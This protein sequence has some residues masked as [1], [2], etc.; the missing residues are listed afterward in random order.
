MHSDRSFVRAGAV[1]VVIAGVAAVLAALAVAFLAKMRSDGE[2][3]G[4]LVGEAQARI[5]LSAGLMYVAET[6]R[7]GW[8]P[9]TTSAPVEAFG[10]VDVRTGLP[11]P[12]DQL[13]RRLFTGDDLTG[14]GTVY[15][16]VGTSV[17]CPLHVLTRPPCA[18]SPQLV[19]NP[20]PGDPTLAWSE[21]VSFTQPN[22]QPIG[23]DFA[24]FLA[25][26]ARIR[27]NSQ[28]MSWFR[29]HR[30]TPAEFV[31][32][33][34]A[35]ASLGYR[36]W[37]EAQGDGAFADRQTFDEIRRSETILWYAA[38]WNPAVY[39]S[40]GYL[41]HFESES[42]RPAESNQPFIRGTSFMN[43]RNFVGSFL[44]IERL[45]EMPPAW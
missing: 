23:A 11:G 33:C 31:I 25:G 14:V 17:R 27:T 40:V 19:A 22:P 5:M 29:V 13:G 30:R 39:S 1:L 35:G 36:D 38:E 43:P 4:A 26:D 24:S 2:E 20:M 16:A 37:N 6:A 41:T 12:R 21:L 42:I 7:L 18:V 34:G 3:S 9:P 28:G 45:G 44:W 8:Q 32:T 10:W 15:P